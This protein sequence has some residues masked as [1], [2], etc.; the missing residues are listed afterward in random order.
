[1][2]RHVRQYCKIANSD[3]GMDKLMD[4]TLQRQLAEQSKEMADMR[5]QMN[6]LANLLEKQLSVVPVGGNQGPATSTTMNKT[7]VAGSATVNN[8]PVTNNITQIQQINIRPWSGE[9]RV[10]IPVTMLRAAFT[11]NPRLAEYCQLSDED[12]VDAEKAAP[13]VME[14][15]V[16]LV[17]RA[18]AD[19]LARNVYLNPRRADQVLVFDE[20]TWRV[21]TLV[22]AIRTLFDGVAEN[23]HRIIVT[24]AERGLLPLDVQA[25]ASWVPNLYEEEPEKYVAKAK[26][27]VSA[28]LANMAPVGIGRSSAIGA[29]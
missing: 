6:R 21:L 19:P 22:E 4:H 1:M 3:E 29:Q 23:I 13:Y 7:L 20:A 25:A 5:A 17:K 9:D 28:H 18:H 15:L 27:Q 16:D 26:P 12:K 8:G 14:A 24:D 10:V 11:E 2:Y